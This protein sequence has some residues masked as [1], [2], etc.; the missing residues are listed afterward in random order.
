VE[1]CTTRTWRRSHTRLLARAAGVPDPE[2][3]W[4][5]AASPTFDNQFATLELDGRSAVLWIER[6]QRDE[7]DNRSIETS[8]ERRLA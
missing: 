2:V 7:A 5:L 6:T 4:C 8:L 1:T 3:S